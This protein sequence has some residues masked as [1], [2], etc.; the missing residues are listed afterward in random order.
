MR[1]PALYVD[2]QHSSTSG[3]GRAVTASPMRYVTQ[4]CSL[5]QCCDCVLLDVN[6]EEMA[7][8]RFADQKLIFVLS[9]FSKADDV[10]VKYFLL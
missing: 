3:N 5:T 4:E 8:N 1:R 2:L 10:G 6:L 9:R 7:R